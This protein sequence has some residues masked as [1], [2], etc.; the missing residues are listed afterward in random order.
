MRLQARAIVADLD[1]E[2]SG[3][4]FEA[5]VEALIGVIGHADR[6]GPLRDYCVGLTAPL[7]RKSVEP[8]AAATAPARTSAQ[9]QSLLHF[10][11]KAPWSDERV[12]A[13]VR[14][15]ATPALER[16]GPVEAWIIDDTTFPKKGRHSVGVAR[17]Y[18]GQ[19]GKQENCQAAVSV[20]IANRGTSLP[21]AYRLYLPQDWAEDPERRAK[22][23]V[24]QEIGFA[25]KPEIA[26]MQIRALKAAGVPEGVVLMD[27]GYG[28]DTAL[29]EAIAALGL[30]YIAGVQSHM[31][32][33][34]AGEGPLP[35]A[36]WSGRGRPPS[37]QRRE[38]GHRPIA[39]KALAFGLPAEAWETVAWREGATGRLSSRFAR[40]RVR[41]AHR[42]E[43]LKAP[44][45]EEWLL[46]EWP[47][48][49]D[50]PTKYW[51]A[52]LPEAIAFD[53][54]VDLVK[55]RWRIERDYQELKQEL[56]LGHYEGRGWRGFHHHATLCIAAYGFLISERETIPPSGARAAAKREKPALPQGYRP[57]GAADPDRAARRQLDRNN[58]SAALGRD[59]QGARPMSCCNAPRRQTAD[60]PNL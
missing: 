5:Y 30:D 44:R 9:H 54:L 1:G 23:G 52:T 39:I 37:R 33:W 17:Q 18:C 2:G 24:P 13:E 56:G 25:T 28:V 21:V 4:R 22:A 20:S 38:A 7:E 6:A 51:L 32:V 26:L 58:A 57:R 12:L 10:V 49:M 50:E 41:P 27:A 59:R 3:A 53:R 40:L 48:D 36:P 46:I 45:P 47:E 11:G 34:L 31:T 60:P 29:R 42:D 16:Y 43:G 15:L 19:L 14:E 55:L 35:P 8:M